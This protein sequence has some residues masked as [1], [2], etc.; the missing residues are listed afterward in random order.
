MST[1]RQIGTVKVE[2]ASQPHGGRGADR[3]A[4]PRLALRAAR[5]ARL[6]RPRAATCSSTSPAA[7]SSTPPSSACCSR[8]SA[9][10]R[11]AHGRCE[12]IIPPQAGYVTRLFEVTGI[13]EPVQRAHVAQRRARQHRGVRAARQEAPASRV[14]AALAQRALAW[15]GMSPR[16]RRRLTEAE[17]ADVRK[18]AHRYL[19]AAEHAAAGGAGPVAA[20]RRRARAPRPRLGA[21]AGRLARGAHAHRPVPARAGRLSRE[22]ASV[23]RLAVPVVDA[24]SPCAPSRRRPCCP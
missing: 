24:R 7:R 21:R 8:P 17:L 14:A 3:R 12:L 22:D 6:R 4:R 23:V 5:H 15:R 9:G 13:A 20:G 19:T 1:E 18:R 2:F 16:K 10:S 11:R